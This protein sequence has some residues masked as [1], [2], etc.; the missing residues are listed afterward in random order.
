MK[1]DTCRDVHGFVGGAC[2]LCSDAL[3]V[4]VCVSNISGASLAAGPRHDGNDT[5]ADGEGGG[6][7]QAECNHGSPPPPPAESLC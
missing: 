5:A 1:T 4:A 2:Q 3:T 6:A 7:V